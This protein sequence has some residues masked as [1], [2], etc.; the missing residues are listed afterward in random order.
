M[1]RDGN[2]G[3]DRRAGVV[4]LLETLGV[5]ARLREGIDEALGRMKEELAENRLQVAPAAWDEFEHTVAHGD[6]LARLTL[7]MAEECVPLDAAELAE[8]I[9]FYE[10][11]AGRR[12]LERLPEINR[13][14]SAASEEWFQRVAGPRI[15]ALIDKSDK[16]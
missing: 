8:V 5:A 9:R 13:A 6:A 12:Y 2:N 4:R 15:E 14:M 10:T 11:P 3:G 7:E 16:P 1:E